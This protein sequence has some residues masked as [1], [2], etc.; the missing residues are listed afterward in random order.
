MTKT[1]ML[2]FLMV[3]MLRFL[4]VTMLRHLMTIVMVMTYYDTFASCSWI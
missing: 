3:T 4:M 1:L 2:R